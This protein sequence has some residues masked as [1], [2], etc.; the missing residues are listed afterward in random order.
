M[1]SPRFLSTTVSLFGPSEASETQLTHGRSGAVCWPWPC[2]LSYL[3]ACARALCS[4]GFQN[5]RRMAPK[6]AAVR[7]WECRAT[8][9]TRRRGPWATFQMVST[10]VRTAWTLSVYTGQAVVDTKGP[11]GHGTHTH[12]SGFRAALLFLSLRAIYSTLEP[13]RRVQSTSLGSSCRH[14][15]LKLLTVCG[16]VQELGVCVCSGHPVIPAR[17]CWADK[18]RTK[19]V[20]HWAPSRQPVRRRAPCWGT[21]PVVTCI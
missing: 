20:G 21:L 8:T 5:G 17:R 11:R 9:Q 16:R 15:E 7:R 4:W 2:W 14:S 19:T 1:H 6:R 18:R 3:G 10:Y 13:Q 12:T